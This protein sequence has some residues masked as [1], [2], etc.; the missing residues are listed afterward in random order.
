MSVVIP[1]PTSKRFKDLTGQEFGRLTVVGY[2][3][4]QH[5]ASLWL[6]RC[7]CG[8]AKDISASA[9]TSGTTKSCGCWQRERM[10]RLTYKHG[11]RSRS[12]PHP[13]WKTWE[14][15]RSRCTNPNDKDWK[16]YGGKGVTVHPEWMQDFAAF[17]RDVGPRPSKRHTLDR[18]DRTGNYEPGNVRWSTWTEQARNRSNNRLVE[19]NGRTML[20]VEAAEAAGIPYRTLKTRLHHGWTIERALAEPV[21]QSKVRAGRM[22][23]KAGRI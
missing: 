18:K 10:A 7:K 13:E 14:Q 3:G 21:D 15:M 8:T 16:W 17:V 11:G 23:A 4:R 5:H 6:C 12:K 1:I 19:F 22:G 2:L 9:L 20:L